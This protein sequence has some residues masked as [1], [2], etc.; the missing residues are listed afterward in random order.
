MTCTRI[1]RIARCETMFRTLP[2]FFQQSIRSP[3]SGS[4]FNLAMQRRT[5]LIAGCS[6]S[7]LGSALAHAFHDRD[8]RVLVSARDLGKA[9]SLK[10][11]GI[12]CIE[13]DALSAES[14]SRAVAKVS[15]SLM[16]D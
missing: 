2:P 13:F 6:D 5:V 16:G 1:H 14:I 8:V 3:L 12:E 10:T 15:S 7:S 4:S 11:K 9:E